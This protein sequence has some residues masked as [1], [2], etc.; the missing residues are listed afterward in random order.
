MLIFSLSL[1]ISGINYKALFFECHQSAQ[2]Y[3]QI[4][5]AELG[6]DVPTL[7]KLGDKKKDANLKPYT[8]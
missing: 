4:I 8:A 3:N 1:F 6:K 7:K 2:C 5:E